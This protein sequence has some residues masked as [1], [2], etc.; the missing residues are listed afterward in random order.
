MSYRGHNRVGTGGEKYKHGYV[1]V[2]K[3]ISILFFVLSVILIPAAVS[4]QPDLTDFSEMF[5]VF[6]EARNIYAGYDLTTKD[7]FQP[8]PESYHLGPGDILQVMAGGAVPDAAI[9]QVDP[10]G[11]LLV[12]PA[13]LIRIKGLT[14]EEARQAINDALAVY[15]KEPKVQLELL[16]PRKVQV[17]LLGQATLPGIYITWAGV[18]PVGFLQNASG[19][20]TTPPAGSTINEKE[21]LSPYFRI[22]NA[23]ASRFVKVLRDKKEIAEIDLADILYNGAKEPDIFLE[24]GDAIYVPEIKRPVIVR[25]G[26]V[27]PGKYEFSNKENLTEVLKMAGGAISEHFLSRVTVERKND[28][29]D[30]L[31]DVS[32]DRNYKPIKAGFELRPG[33]IVRVPDIN[34]YVYV[35]GGVFL[36][37]AIE[38]KENW[39]VIDYIGQTG[40][41]IAPADSAYTRII[42]HAGTPEA[43]AIQVDIKEL[44]KGNPVENPVVEPGDIIFVPFDNK[45]WGG[46]MVTGTIL[47]FA[48]FARFLW[49]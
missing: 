24:D 25:G 19:L 7:F 20:V 44:I 37:K 45:V 9:F 22:L 3:K 41:I 11:K 43:K 14:I 23:S 36:P 21:F 6:E 18:T 13:G 34:N 16:Q 26:V 28:F 15:I 30:E 40:G 31:L 35:F 46:P 38:Y 2:M 29:G 10:Q 4:A 42:K 33:D 49:G 32:I 17:Y 8:L 39:R 12:Y 27:R 47:Q 1:V 48:T 5:K